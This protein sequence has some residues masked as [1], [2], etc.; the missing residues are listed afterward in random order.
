MLFI[1][2][3]IGILT[4][5]KPSNNEVVLQGQVKGPL[6]ESIQIKLCPVRNLPSNIIYI[7]L[8]SNGYYKTRFN[9]N[10]PAYAMMG[11]PMNDLSYIVLLIIQPG[12]SLY[13]DFLDGYY[14]LPFNNDS[15]SSVMIGGSNMEGQVLFNRMVRGKFRFLK[16]SYETWEKVT[17]KAIEDS[18]SARI[19]KDIKAVK[20]LWETNK[21]NKK[22]YEILKNIITYEH[23]FMAE[24]T[25][26]HKLK[27]NKYRNEADKSLLIHEI[28][29]I[30]ENHPI[31]NEI[32]IYSQR[33]LRS[34]IHDYLTNKRII[35]EEVF[36]KHEEQGT[37]YTY[38]LNLIKQEVP[39]NVYKFYAISWL[40]GNAYFKNYKELITIYE[41]Y[42]SA[43]PNSSY[44]EP[45]LNELPG[46][47]DRIKK[48]HHKTNKPEENKDEV[49]LGINIHNKSS[50]VNTL[51]KAVGELKGKPVFVELWATWCPPCIHEIHNSDSLKQFLNSNN[52]EMLY[53]SYDK[54]GYY[55]TWKNF[56][57]EHDVKGNHIIATDSLKAAL[58][59]IF[60]IKGIPYFFL[61]DENGDIAGKDLKRPSQFTELKKQINDSLK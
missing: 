2:I 48:V 1:F 23:S 24:R 6:P 26:L 19:L 53:I 38:Q 10:K 47:I 8:D 36:S 43:Y 7:N 33:I 41:D 39:D 50:S 22:H 16:S 57:K 9:I 37:L 13:I 20:D 46:F 11:G 32:I 55:N 3:A 45:Y 42:I 12:D 14:K 29:K 35:N 58:D 44:K 59:S 60:D 56:I 40:W 52:I 54:W 18:L 21:I 4:G 15:L 31:D 61:I 25:L 49:L 17:I 51:D 27:E 28:G 34:Y 30:F 5:C